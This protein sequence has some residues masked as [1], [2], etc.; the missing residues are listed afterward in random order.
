MREAAAVCVM[1]QEQFADK[2]I[3]YTSESGRYSFNSI[4][5][6]DIIQKWIEIFKIETPGQRLMILFKKIKSSVQARGQKHK[7]FFVRVSRPELFLFDVIGR[8]FLHF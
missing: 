2:H 4:L 6:C 5:V 1:G 8:H 7:M 3:L